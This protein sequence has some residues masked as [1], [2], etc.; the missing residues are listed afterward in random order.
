[1]QLP[2]SIYIYIYIN[3]FAH[4]C[5]IQGLQLLENMNPTWL[6]STWPSVPA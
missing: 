6:M 3:M 4:K 2:P 5:S 1:M